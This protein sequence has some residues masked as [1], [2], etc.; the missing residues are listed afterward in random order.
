MPITHLHKSLQ[1]DENEIVKLVLDGPATVYLLDSSN[2]F[3]FMQDRPYEF[4]GTEVA[5]SPFLMTPPH[6]GPWE[7]VIF[8]STPGKSVHA[9]ISIVER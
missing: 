4:H 1:L 3:L 7:L 5:S 2:Y 6:P 9:E 8:T